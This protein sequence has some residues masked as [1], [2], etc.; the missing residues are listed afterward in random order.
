MGHHIPAVGF[1]LFAFP[2]KITYIVEVV[3]ISTEFGAF[4]KV[5][6]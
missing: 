1:L 4:P 2:S 6:K 5:N 3:E